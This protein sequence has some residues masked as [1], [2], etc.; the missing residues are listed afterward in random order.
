MLKHTLILFCLLT[1]LLFKPAS[2]SGQSTPSTESGEPGQ[3]PGQTNVPADLQD[4]EDVRAPD[5]P[6]A[7]ETQA[8]ASQDIFDQI[9]P[10]DPNTSSKDPVLT[11]LLGDLEARNALSPDAPPVAIG[12]PNSIGVPITKI[13]IDLTRVAP[14][15][16]SA[17][18]PLY[19]EGGFL[20]RERGQI[21]R[22][23]DDQFIAFQ[24]IN[25]QAPGALVN[26]KL[27]ARVVILQPNRQL[28]SIQN[29]LARRSEEAAPLYQ[30]S[31]QVHAYRGVNYLLIT[32]A[33]PVAPIT[34]PVSGSPGT[35]GSSPADGKNAKATANDKPKEQGNTR[36]GSPS[37]VLRRMLD[38]QATEPDWK[39]LQ[40]RVPTTQKSGSA[41][42]SQTKRL[43]RR[44][45]SNGAFNDALTMANK[46]DGDFV[47]AR[48]GRLTRST[49][50]GQAMF[51]F[52]AD[53]SRAQE[54]PVT[55]F[56]CRLLERMEDQITERGDAVVFEVTGQ[57]HAYRGTV[58][59]LP[60]IARLTSSKSSLKP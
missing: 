25:T 19:P 56:P 10:D 22:D 7:N 14:D 9:N 53:S 38:E 31:G 33:R 17:T 3:T 13:G 40:E 60:T 18:E 50:S 35:P 6:D 26:D 46:L 23:P 32:Q 34:L 59:L 16:S 1:A 24:F 15:Y 4:P 27:A 41:Q 28:E 2:V 47:M 43:E 44:S 36:P 42:N 58:Y 55:V 48:R 49:Q 8:R 45:V 5:A 57:L 52:N 54:P 51:S 21:L 29:Q 30:L 20:V 39:M 37:E 11:R 12:V